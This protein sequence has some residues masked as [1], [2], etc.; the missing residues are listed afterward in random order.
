MLSNRG[1]KEGMAKNNYSIGISLLAV[2]FVL[3]LGKLGVFSF[4]GS[5]FWPIFIFVPGLLLHF[6]YFGRVLP[7]GVLIPGGILVTYS[8]LFFYSN[9]FGWKTMGYIWPGFLF[10]IAVGLYEYYLFDRN[11]P[12]AALTASLVLAIASA[13]LF[14]FIFL[15]KAGIYFIV[16]LLVLAG[17]FMVL[18]RPKR[19]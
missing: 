11:S 12:K 14:G 5:L 15:F 18:R 7:S 16:F 13:V 1:G 3:L 4:L 2:A 6:L 17:I 19:W 8:L 10:G 9:I